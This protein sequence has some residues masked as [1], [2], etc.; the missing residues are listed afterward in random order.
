[1]NI[2]QFNAMSASE[3]KQVLARTCTASRWIEKMIA[4]RPIIDL[5]D[6][7]EKA[8]KIWLEMT[9]ADY[10]EAFDG[11]PKIG[12]PG[13]LKKKYGDTRESAESEQSGVASADGDTLEHLAKMNHQYLEKFGYIFIVCATGK[14]AEQMLTLLRT[15]YQNAPAAELEI[16]ADEQRKIT[17]IR[18]EKLFT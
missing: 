4:C 12:D 1:M 11:H 8:R 3:A 6:F 18:I 10:L 14:S 2:D 15:R 9:E 5:E 16:A 13:S 17:A 7:Q